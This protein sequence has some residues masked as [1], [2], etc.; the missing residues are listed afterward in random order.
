MKSRVAALLLL[1]AALIAP[2]RGEP[3]R[4]IVIDGKFDDWK[5]V[6]AYKDAANNEHDTD[7]NK[8]DDKPKRVDHPDVDILEYKFTHDRDSVYA[9]FKARG[10]IGRTQVGQGKQAG[11]YY[12]IVTI[13]AD[14]NPATGYWLHEGGY[15]PT[16]RGYD[17]NAEIEWLGGQ[18][19]TG[20]YIN[21]E[22]RDEAELA[23]AFL[24]QSVGQYKKDRPG[25][26]KAGFVRLGPGTYKYYTQWVYHDNGTIT[27]VRDKGPRTL[28]II[29]GALSTDGHELEMV[30]PMKGFLIDPK[31]EPIVKLGRTINISMSLEASGE[32]APGGCWA[33]NTAQPIRG[34]VLEAAGK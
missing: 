26:Y 15:Y 29:K 21:H 32:L 23:Q 8:A 3:P 20:H 14:N 6:P 27:F 31:G 30:M 10:V 13:D 34:Y 7:H 18:I 24:D 22:C 1:L 25:P 16:S 19:N 12:A 17:V 11:R 4:A 5:D 2:L 9:Y 33:S 28:G